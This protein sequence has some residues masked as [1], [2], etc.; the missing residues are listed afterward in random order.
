VRVVE[1]CQLD[2][3]KQYRAA[4]IEAGIEFIQGIWSEC[5][6][7]YVR[8]SLDMLSKILRLPERFAKTPEAQEFTR[9][10][11]SRDYAEFEA[12]FLRKHLEPPEGE[13]EE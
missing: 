10:I 9:A 7:Q 5:D 12:K 11:V 4:E 1:L 8:G 3:F 2:D 13:K 6:P